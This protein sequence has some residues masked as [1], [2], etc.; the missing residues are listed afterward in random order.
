M[1]ATVEY[2]GKAQGHGHVTPRADG[3]KAR[4]G[5]P[6]LCQVCKKEQAV[7]YT[8]PADQVDGVVVSRGLLERLFTSNSKYQFDPKTYWPAHEELR[9]LL[10]TTERGNKP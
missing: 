4:C 10:A 5:G 3:V 9:A 8:H 6:T 2:V 1:P 7:L